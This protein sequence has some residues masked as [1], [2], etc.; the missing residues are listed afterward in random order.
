ML[1]ERINKKA[2]NDK[3][4]RAYVM[5]TFREFDGLD[6]QNLKNPVFEKLN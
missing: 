3:G 4:E 5:G 2:E 6:V 1:A